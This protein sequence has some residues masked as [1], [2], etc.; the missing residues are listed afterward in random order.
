[1]KS[2]KK[3]S[4]SRRKFLKYAGATAA[5]LGL[6]ACGKILNSQ[7]PGVPTAFQ[8]LTNTPTLPPTETPTP[9]NTPEPTRSPLEQAIETQGVAQRIPAIE[10]HGLRFYME[11]VGQMTAEWFED[12]M[13]WLNENNFHAVTRDQLNGYL[14]G[15]TLLP[16]KSILLTFDWGQNVSGQVDTELAP[17]LQKYGMHGLGFIQAEDRFYNEEL[18]PKNACW[19]HYKN[20]VDTGII[21]FGSH[22]INHYYLSQQPYSVVISELADSKKRIEDALG[23]KV[24]SIAWPFED[25]PNNWADVLTQTGYK[26]A[27][28]GWARAIAECQVHP[29]DPLWG[30][31]PRLL[32]YSFP[33]DYPKLTSREPGLTFPEM[34]MA[35]ITPP[36]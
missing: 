20:W 25:I 8:A 27:F 31:L 21:D 7:T 26:S 15:D 33:G 11:G 35:N 30:N 13:R 3:S 28:G 24:D 9:T 2:S 10:Y 16:A 14:H 32:P 29:R 1:M 17:I 5:V 12:Q 19:N 36:K 6:D 18:C 34:V 22:T 4:L 23:V